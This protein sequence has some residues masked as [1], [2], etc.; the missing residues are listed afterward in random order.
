[1]LSNHP[2]AI[3]K[4]SPKMVDKGISDLSSN[5]EEFDKVKTIYETVTV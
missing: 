1:M 4:Q 3:I 5:K 2:P